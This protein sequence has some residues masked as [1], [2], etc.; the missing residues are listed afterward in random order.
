MHKLLLIS[1]ARKDFDNLPEKIFKQ[2][3]KKVLSL[4]NNPR[5]RGC[6]KLTSDEGYRVRNG[7]YRILYRIDDKKKVVY[8]YRIKHRRESYR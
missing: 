7:D 4:K 2:I 6:L 5:P 8:I 1:A 3:K